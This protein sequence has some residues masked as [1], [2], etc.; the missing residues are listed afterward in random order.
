MTTYLFSEKTLFTKPEEKGN[1]MKK[2]KLMKIRAAVKLGKKTKFKI[3][4]LWIVQICYPL[5]IPLEIV[6]AIYMEKGMFLN[7]GLLVVLLMILES[8]GIKY[9]I[10][11]QSENDGFS[12]KE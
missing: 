2:S 7:S 11:A 5:L 9:W 8:V 3:K 10:F 6:S 1:I 4:P 12:P